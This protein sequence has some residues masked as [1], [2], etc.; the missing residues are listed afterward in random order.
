[1]RYRGGRHQGRPD[2]PRRHRV[3]EPPREIGCLLAHPLGHLKGVRNPAGQQQCADVRVGDVEPHVRSVER[4]SR[5]GVSRVCDGHGFGGAPRV[6]GYGSERPGC[7][8]ADDGGQV[9][10]RK[11]FRR[12]RRRIRL[13]HRK[14][15]HRE[16]GVDIA[17]GLRRCGA[18][19]V[20]DELLSRARGQQAPRACCW[21]AGTRIWRG[22]R[23]STGWW[24][25]RRAPLRPPGHGRA[26]TMHAR[27]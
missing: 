21:P 22:R 4:A 8:S 10:Q 15:V 1:M 19:R 5:N 23:R 26:T 3:I 7:L 14:P 13:V 12:L 6:R 27:E 25:S 11:V 24:G 16:E 18:R 9:V 17:A 20:V 2:P